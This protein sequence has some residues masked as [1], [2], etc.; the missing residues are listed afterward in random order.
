MISANL[1]DLRFKHFLV[2]VLPLLMWEDE[3]DIINSNY[4]S[5]SSFLYGFS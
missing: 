1:A 2:E 3:D 4:G 5:Y